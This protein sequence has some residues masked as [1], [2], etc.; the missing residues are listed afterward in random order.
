MEW[1]VP[2][3][4]L[5]TE[6][7]ILKPKIDLRL[8]K[9]FNSGRFILGEQVKEFEQRMAAYLHVEDCVGVNSGSD[10]ML[11]ALRAVEVG[12]G[13]EVITVAHTHIST[14]AVI[15]YVGAVPVLVD[16]REDGN[17]NPV[18]LEKAVTPKTKAVIIVHLNGKPCNM[19]EIHQSLYGKSITLIEDACQS[20]GA[21]WGTKK[22]GTFGIGCFS[23]HPLK[24][25][26]AGGDGGLVTCSK[27]IGKKIRLLRNHGTEDRINYTDWGY[28]SRLDEIQAAI[29]NVKLEH[30]DQWI[31]TRRAIARAY[32][33][34]LIKL[35]EITVP[36]S[37]GKTY[38]TF[39]SYT[40]L[41][42][43]R[44]ELKGF[45]TS[46]GIETMISWDPPIH[47]QMDI[48]YKLPVTEMISKR[49]LSL[50]VHQY[51]KREQIEYVCESIKEFYANLS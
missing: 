43:G 46:K 29:L 28:N 12:E 37:L 11:L 21:E 41:A 26:S 38:N 14:I 5:P 48:P 25:L 4:D 8:A 42:E 31:T 49:V 45:L 1:K 51:L 40:V 19:D 24:T 23:F 9:V 15:G 27:E 7:R 20:L 36:N 2:Y 10:A 6:Y 47:I 44:D 13:D 30:L 50:P 39:N 34:V 22:V 17:I 32:N 3:I 16:V 33:L 18:E 35:H